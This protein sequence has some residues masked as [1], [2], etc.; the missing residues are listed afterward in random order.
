MFLLWFAADRAS[1]NRHC[2]MAAFP[3]LEIPVLPLNL[4]DSLSTASSPA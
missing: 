3:F 1:M 2:L 4:P